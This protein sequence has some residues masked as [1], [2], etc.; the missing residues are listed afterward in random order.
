M[1]KVFFFLNLFK[2]CVSETILPTSYK[3]IEHYQRNDE[4]RTVIDQIG[5]GYF[6]AGDS[7]LFSSL[8]DSLMHEDK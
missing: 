1:G 8:V 5:S 4:L 2:I 6:S 7:G 3:P